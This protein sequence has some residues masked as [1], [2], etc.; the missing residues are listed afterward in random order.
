MDSKIEEINKLKNFFY[1]SNILDY[2]ALRPL[3]HI[4]ENWELIWNNEKNKYEDEENSYAD[5]LNKLIDEISLINPP[6]KYHINEDCLAIYVK[7]NLN[8][9]IYKFNG[10]WIG[11]DYISIMQQG[12]FHDVKLCNLKMAA[13]GRVKAAIERGQL[14]FDKMEQSHQKILAGVISIILYHQT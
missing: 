9:N 2:L 6:K 10:R 13:T 5:K 7:D 3:S 11:E 12:G 8:W 1:N 4:N 14:H